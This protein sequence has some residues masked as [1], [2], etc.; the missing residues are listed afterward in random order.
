[1]TFMKMSERCFEKINGRRLLWW[2]HTQADSSKVSPHLLGSLTQCCEPNSGGHCKK[3]LACCASLCKSSL[4]VAVE[5]PPVDIAITRVTNH[6]GLGIFCGKHIT[7]SFWI[8]MQ[9]VMKMTKVMM[10]II[11]WPAV[12]IFRPSHIC[13]WS[14]LFRD[15]Q[16][17]S[18]FADCSSSSSSS[19]SWKKKKFQ[20]DF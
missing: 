19:L 1:M 12:P 4:C 20:T 2:N 16:T 17:S 3:L 6:H 9:M 15:N 11:W 7:V 18:D 14:P 5:K 8:V 13:R 10:I